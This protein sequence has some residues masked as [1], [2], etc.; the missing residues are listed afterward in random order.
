MLDASKGSADKESIKT[1]MHKFSQHFVACL[2]SRELE[3]W[4][5]GLLKGESESGE[6]LD[7]AIALISPLT[8][9]M[10]PTTTIFYHLPL[11]YVDNL[12][13]LPAT[14]WG[15]IRYKIPI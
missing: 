13:A 9:S 5:L 10:F 4:D 2:V 8:C 15:R 11:T 3:T 12:L 6:R 7:E 1:E 14:R